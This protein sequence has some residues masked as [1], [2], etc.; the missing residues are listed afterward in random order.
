MQ[1]PE[2]EEPQ[3]LPPLRPALLREPRLTTAE[4]SVHLL[5]VRVRAEIVQFLLALVIQLFHHVGRR[6][7]RQ[8]SNSS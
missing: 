5:L 3:V 4:H 7:R 1:S 6:C 8:A 2:D